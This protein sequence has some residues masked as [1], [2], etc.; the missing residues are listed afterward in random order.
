MESLP[1]MKKKDK[2]LAK[3]QDRFDKARNKYGEKVQE[4][5]LWEKYYNG[6]HDIRSAKGV[7]AKKDATNVRNIVFELIESEVDS[8]VPMPRVTPV[9]E[10]DKEIAGK[11][12]ALLRN[13][14]MRLGFDV[15]ND[16]QERITTTD[17]ADFWLVEWDMDAGYH[18]TVGDIAV[19]HIHP[20]QVIP[21]PGVYDLDKME[22]FFVMTSRTKEAVQKQFGVDLARAAETEPDVRNNADEQDAGGADGLVTQV[23][24]YYKNGKGGIG[25]ISWADDILLRHENDYQ[26]RKLERCKKCGRIKTDKVCTCGSKTFEKEDENGFEIEET[27]V[28]MGPGGKRAQID[29]YE[30]A[31]VYGQN[32]DGSPMVEVDEAGTPVLDEMGLPVPVVVNQTRKKVKVPYYKPNTFPLVMR[33]NISV[34]GSFVGLSDV[35]P[36]ADQQEAIK[37]FGTKID[38][39]ILKGGSFVT[40]PRGVSIETSDKDFK[41][42]RLDNP[43][44]KELMGVFNVQPD[45]SKEQVQLEANYNWAKSSL[46]I[47]DSFQGK[48]DSTATSGTAK[49]FSANQSAGRLMSKK[50]MKYAAYAKLYETMFKFLLAY[51]DDPLPYQTQNENGEIVFDHFDPKELLR[52]DAAGQPYWNDEFYFTVDESATIASNREMLWNMADVKFQ[53]GAFGPINDLQSAYILW[54]WLENTGYPGAGPVRRSVEQRMN[55][56]IEQQNAAMPRAMPD[57]VDDRT[58]V[59]QGDLTNLHEM[60]VL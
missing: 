41:I 55:A 24:C 38:E 43:A 16:L 28:T 27:I 13:E 11:I 54:T 60:G 59:Q 26:A 18:S 30:E 39:K 36:I 7:Q 47:T 45:I 1:D 4:M 19:S 23:D 21:Q 40:L 35:K 15:L 14:G 50:K 29:P 34:Y 31:P 53:A 20:R 8:S 51:A 42:V 25:R 52:V 57:G 22:Y 6:T 33:K 10:E 46:G 58:S 48:A 2:D 56:Q 3:W 17:G 44:H 9:H 37:K 32:P 12:E 5:L 49:Q